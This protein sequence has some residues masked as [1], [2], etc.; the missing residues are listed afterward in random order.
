MKTIEIKQT[1][2]AVLIVATIVI[3]MLLSSCSTPQNCCGG[4]KSYNNY[5]PN[6]H[7]TNFNKKK[8]NNI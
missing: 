3:T 1:V 4:K 6:T 5:K 2:T 8:Y 7:K